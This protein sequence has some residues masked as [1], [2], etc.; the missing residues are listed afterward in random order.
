MWG[1]RKFKLGVGNVGVGHWGGSSLG[2]LA[3]CCR[4]RLF[5][6]VIARREP[7]KCQANDVAISV[8]LLFLR[9]VPV[10]YEGVGNVQG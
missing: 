7:D 8:C 6:N 1:C 10:I 9:G 2:V 3:M 5:F 4:L